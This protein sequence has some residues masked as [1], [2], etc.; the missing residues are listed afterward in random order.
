M[1]MCT[2]V[3]SGVI[4]RAEAAGARVHDGAA[5]RGALRGVG[6]RARG[7]RGA[8]RPATARQLAR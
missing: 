4:G 3:G 7:V 6:G 8:R 1:L 5:G 2:C